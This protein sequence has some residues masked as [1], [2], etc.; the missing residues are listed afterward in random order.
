MLK[1]ASRYVRAIKDYYVFYEWKLQKHPVLYGSLIALLII[2]PLVVDWLAPRDWQSV[3]FLSPIVATALAIAGFFARSLT[4]YGPRKKEFR[5]NAK[6][7]ELT[8]NVKPS[9]LE[10][11]AGFETVSPRNGAVGSLMCP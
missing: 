10:Q 11:A 2:V 7:L 5:S 6:L 8:K 1:V 3:A 4:A 9:Q